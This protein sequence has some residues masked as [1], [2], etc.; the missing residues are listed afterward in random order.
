[1]GQD[2]QARAAE[3]IIE[4]AARPVDLVTLW[5][6]TTEVLAEAVP[7]YWTPCWYA[8]DPASLLI[9]SHYHDGLDEFPAD[10]L[11]NEYYQDDVNKLVDVATSPAGVST[12]FEATDGRPES[13]PRWHTNMTLG[14][15]QEMIVRL[16]TADGQVWGMLGLYREPGRPMFDDADKRLLQAV[17]PHL[18]AAARRA[19]LLGEATDPDSPDAPGL[20]VLDERWDVVSTTPGVERW[21]AEL[22]DGD[23]AA[24]RLPSAV[25]SVAARALAAARDSV[26]RHQVAVARVLA[27]NGTWLVLHGA[28]MQTRGE[29]QVAVIIEAATPSRIFPL[30]VSAYGLTEREREI[31]ELVLA[32]SSTA[33][34][35]ARLV[36]SPHTVQQHLKSIFDKTGVN[37]RRDLVGRIFFTHYEPRFRDN[38]SRT[39]GRLPLRGGPAARR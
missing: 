35:A 15:D 10:W 32:G 13:S 31:T 28:R 22:P 6:D 16:R 5:R 24:G 1:M 4:L 17:A 21:L 39:A 29:R 2:R 33:Q 18:A 20:V 27:R 38:E 25:Q 19:L 23:L 14:G 12:L 11:A 7:F 34:I 3:R 9:T 36:I 26:P 30:L 37:S 8:L